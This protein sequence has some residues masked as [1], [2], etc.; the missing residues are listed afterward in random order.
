MCQCLT[1]RCHN[2][3]I[4]TQASTSASRKCTRNTEIL[5]RPHWSW[6]QHFRSHGHKR[7]NTVW[8]T[9]A[10]TT[11]AVF[12]YVRIC[13]P[14]QW[15][16]GLRR[17]RRRLLYDWRSVSQSVC[18]GMSTLLALATRYF[19][20]SEICG[21]VSVG[22]PLWREDRS[23]ICSVITR[24]SESHR[25]RNHTLLSHPHACMVLGL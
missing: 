16:H 23:E 17:R 10:Q 3:P 6:E 25:T 11:P 1:A 21:L 13:E 24:W 14:M 5:N 2:V 22:H 15:P 18:L 8:S 7:S 4:F 9:R 19:F 20:L 12:C